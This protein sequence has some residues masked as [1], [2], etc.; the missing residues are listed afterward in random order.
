MRQ[1]NVDVANQVPRRR[2]GWECSH[3][4]YHAPFVFRWDVHVPDSP[5]RR[6]NASL[7]SALSG[8]PHR[9]VHAAAGH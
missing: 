9:H 8:T 3:Q 4:E 2:E 7:L 6:P 1:V 5:V